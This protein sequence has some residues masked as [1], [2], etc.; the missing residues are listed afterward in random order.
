M[1]AVMPRGRERPKEDTRRP[2]RDEEDEDDDDPDDDNYDP[3]NDEDGNAA[4]TDEEDEDTEDMEKDPR[5]EQIAA[6]QKSIT[7]LSTQL[8]RLTKAT[9][10]LA[11][12]DDYVSETY[13]TEALFKGI[14]SEFALALSPLVA[15]LEA[16]EE[17][18]ETIQKALDQGAV[19]W[20]EMAD[21]QEVIQKALSVASPEQL[22]KALAAKGTQTDKHTSA[23]GQ[24]QPTGAVTTHDVLSKGSDCEGLNDDERT[25][26]QEL[27]AKAQRLA[28]DY[29]IAA[30]G[31]EDAVDAM[32]EG[33][34]NRQTYQALRKG[35]E[36][37]SSNA[38]RLIKA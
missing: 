36:V 12:P 9:E 16:L 8:S 26:V 20:E 33:H 17:G 21:G 13:T 24:T 18:N 5:D 29:S 3:A 31:Y 11:D 10:P 38:E 14:G 27:L 34:F 1:A 2:S 19:I 35:V 15:R 28:R 6:M 7:R 22:T 25:E 32:N 37:A 4:P 23:E 30:D